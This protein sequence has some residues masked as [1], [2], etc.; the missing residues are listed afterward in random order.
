MQNSAFR[1][2]VFGVKITLLARSSF[3]FNA[4]Q[5]RLVDRVEGCRKAALHRS[6]LKKRGDY[7]VT[8]EKLAQNKKDL[9]C[10]KSLFNLVARGGIEPP[11]QGFSIH[12]I[13]C[14]GVLIAI[15]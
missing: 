6:S 11:T 14:F 5:Q 2:F 10:C 8:D 7:M 15:P 3:T 12:E 4:R 1:Q 9:H 13:W